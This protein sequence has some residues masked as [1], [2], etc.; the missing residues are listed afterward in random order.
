MSENSTVPSC[1]IALVTPFVLTATVI[2]RLSTV[3][4]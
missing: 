3:I 4:P 2:N 1:I